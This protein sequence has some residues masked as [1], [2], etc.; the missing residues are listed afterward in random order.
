[1]GAISDE[2][3][4]RSMLNPVKRE[5]GQAV[6]RP[7]RKAEL[8]VQYR[9][10]SVRGSYRQLAATLSADGLVMAEAALPHEARPRPCKQE[11]AGLNR[12]RLHQLGAS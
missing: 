12:Q 2:N 7:T 3:A 8:S 6:R 5:T 1:M 4:Q 9:A 11:P 10:L